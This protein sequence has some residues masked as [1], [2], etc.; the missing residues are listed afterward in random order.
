MVTAQ[1]TANDTS[2]NLKNGSTVV[3]GDM[4]IDQTKVM[5]VPLASNPMNILRPLKNRD[6]VTVF[7]SIIT[8]SAPNDIIKN[9]SYI[10]ADGHI[11]SK[12]NGPGI[13]E[14]DA[15]NKVSIKAPTSMVWGHK[16]PY[17]TAIKNGDTL[18]IKQKDKTIKTIKESDINNDTVPTDYVT[19]E[20]LKTWMNSSQDGSNITLD[21][22]LG[23]FNDKRNGVY[24]KENITRDFGNETYGY[25]RNY[26]PGAPVMVY[27]HNATETNVSSAVSTV[28][29]L[30]EYP[31]EIRASNAKEFAVGWNNTIIPPHSAA[32]GKENVTFTSIAESGAASGSATHG[33]CPPG[34]SLRDAIMALGNPLPVGMSGA[35]E[36]ILYEFRPTADVLV[37]NNGD[38][39]IKIVMWTEG[40]NGDTKIYTTIYELKDNA[41]YTNMTTNQTI[42]ENS[43]D[44]STT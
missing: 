29:Y 16:L 40:E 9:N 35:E 31:T 15:D 43:T 17:I 32:H 8:A 6:I 28:E 44:N 19:A 1:S 39:P 3:S 10:T 20:N 7:N 11:S 38:Y 25:M 24:G 37:T 4:L 13:V 22:Y 33:V 27:E 2:I 26:T 30:P 21:Y 14:L 18:T 34:R 41:T 42:K 23:D 5:K 36:A 12:L